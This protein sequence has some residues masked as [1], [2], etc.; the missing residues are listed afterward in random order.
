MNYEF[1]F[2]SLLQSSGINSFWHGRLILAR[3]NHF[4]YEPLQFLTFLRDTSGLRKRFSATVWSRAP[5]SFWLFLHCLLNC[6]IE[7]LH[8][9]T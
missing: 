1:H 5:S 8:K 2:Y 3:L 6:F 4:I 7:R 9:L